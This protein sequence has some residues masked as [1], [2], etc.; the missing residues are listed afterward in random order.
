MR[1]FIISF[2]FLLTVLSLE[3]Q[4]INGIRIDGGNAPVLVYIDGKQ[5][6]LPATT[7]FV[8]NLRPSYYR[9][10]IYATRYTKPGE[11]TWKGERL[12]NERFYF[13]GSGVNDIVLGRQEDKRPDRND[14]GEYRP[15][16][17]RYGRVMNDKLFEEFLSGVKKEPFSDSRIKIVETALINSDFTCEQCISITKFYSFSDD[18]K[19]VMKMMYPR[20]VD[21]EGFFTVISL[22]TF[23]SDRDEMN[24]FV[25]KQSRQK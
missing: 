17:D 2:C 24:D 18:K 12:Y 11:R 7:C 21:K 14:R 23:S 25:R 22:L 15:K 10:E 4:T 20:I 13:N 16:Q 5:I 3:A 1:K 8:A 6:N 19:K 9:I